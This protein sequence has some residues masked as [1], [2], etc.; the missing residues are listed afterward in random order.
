MN[1]RPISG[2]LEFLGI[3]VDIFERPANSR[4]MGP[5]LAL[6]QLLTREP[7]QPQTN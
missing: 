5:Q 2:L 6:A 1:S 7:Q 4:E 3:L